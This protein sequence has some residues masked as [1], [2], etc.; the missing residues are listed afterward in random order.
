MEAVSIGAIIPFLGALTSPDILMENH[1]VQTLIGWCEF[2]TQEDL[3]G[4]FAVSFAVLALISGAMRTLLLW[5][6]V[7]LSYAITIDFDISIYNR[8][9]NQ[10]YSYHLSQNS[11]DIISAITIK[12]SQVTVNFIIPLLYIFSSTLIL[13]SILGILF[14]SSPM[15]TLVTL[16]GFS[17]IYVIVFILVKKYLR[18]SSL[19]ISLSQNKTIRVLQESLGGI[20]DV[21]ID[22]LQSAYSKEYKG[23]DFSL[24]RAQG[25]NQIIANAPRF[26]VESFAIVVIVAIAYIFFSSPGSEKNAILLLGVIAFGSQRLLPVF[27]QVFSSVSLIKGVQKTTEDVI[28]LLDHPVSDVGGCKFQESR[29]VMAFQNC[30]EFHNVSFRYSEDTPW[31]LR[32]VNIKFQK[33]QKIGIMGSTGSGKSTFVDLLM[34]L[35][36]PTEGKVTIDGVTLNR[37]KIRSWQSNIAHVPQHIYLFDSTIRDNIAYGV[38]KED[39]NVNR[40]K[41]AAEDA[42]ISNSIESWSGRYDTM[43]GENGIKLSGGQRQRI[44]IA[45]ALYKRSNVIVLDEATSAIDQDTEE[46]IMKAIY[47][48]DK[49]VTIFMIAHRLGTLERCTVLVEVGDKTVKLV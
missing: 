29:N 39:V 31:I 27:Q 33:G 42:C 12:T 46:Q 34:G 41:Q 10:P 5:W 32:N 13:I 3:L 25:N 28:S 11:S 6:Q 47:G 26:G 14:L 23:H 43:V 15:V 44:G 49:S 21:I 22:N 36:I 45:R 7:R 2:E 20:R 40:V 4:F 24:R 16:S 19:V 48:I 35:L 38:S 37:K 1:Y 9:L 8:I 30:I 17:V 18:Q